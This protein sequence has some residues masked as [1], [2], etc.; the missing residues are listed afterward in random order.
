MEN[1]DLAKIYENEEDFLMPEEEPVTSKRDRIYRMKMR[2]THIRR[3]KD[4]LKS[5][6]D[7]LG[8]VE[9]MLSKGKVHCSCP[10]CCFSGYTYREQKRSE[11]MLSDLKDAGGSYTACARA[12]EGL[13]RIVRNSKA[14]P[15]E[16]WEQQPTS[17]KISPAAIEMARSTFR[18][19]SE[20]V[21]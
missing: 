16:D 20:V 11:A 13:K 9:G 5:H 4:I 17:L 7:T 18:E 6:G 3:K 2:E 10:L 12:T 19:R 8:L 15:Y 1:M 14:N 21:A